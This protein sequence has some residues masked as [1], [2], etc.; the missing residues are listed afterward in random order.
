MAAIFEPHALIYY[1][2]FKIFFFKVLDI[3]HTII[4]IS[5]EMPP[6]IGKKVGFHFYKNILS[7]INL[8]LTKKLP[9]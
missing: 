8:P 7:E 4:K 5:L 6:K 9:N 1:R 3:I 2:I